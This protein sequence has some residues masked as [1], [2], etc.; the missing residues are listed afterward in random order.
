MLAHIRAA[1]QATG[2]PVRVIRRDRVPRCGP[3][4]GIYT[5]LKT[6][7]AD[8][9]V[10]LACDMPFVS[11]ELLKRLVAQLSTKRA[12]VFAMCGRDAGFPLVIRVNALPVIEDQMMKRTFSLQKLAAA[13]KTRRLRLSK[14][15]HGELQN[16]NTPE[17]WKILDQ[18]AT[19]KFSRR[20]FG[21]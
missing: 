6:S 18:A 11:A 17:E 13:L 1:A 5:A 7:R 4:G 15:Q 16:I 2:W 10:F 14:A 3:L 9:E 8:A 12:A 20:Q 21:D 19:E